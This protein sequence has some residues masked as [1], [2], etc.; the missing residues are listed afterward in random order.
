MTEK[1]NTRLETLAE[2]D[3]VRMHMPGHKGR[4]SFPN[5]YQIDFTEITGSDDLHHPEEILKALQNRAAALYNTGAAVILPGSTTAGIIGAMLAF[6]RPGDF[7]LI[8][9]NAHRS[10]Y[11]A[12]AFGRLTPVFFSPECL[13]TQHTVRALLNEHPEASG[14]LIVSPDYFGRVANLP[15]IAS[16]AHSRGLRLITDAAHG[17][18]LHFCSYDPALMQRAGTESDAL[19]QSTHKTLGAFTQTALLHTLNEEDAGAIARMLALFESSSP[20]YLLMAGL[21]KALDQAE[22]SAALV[23]KRIADRHAACMAAQ[24]STDPIQLIRLSEPYDTSKWLYRTPQGCGF[25]TEKLLEA[26]GIYCELAFP[27]GVL[28]MTGIGTTESDIDALE[29][30]IKTCCHSF[31]GLSCSTGPLFCQER[32]DMNPALPMSDAV[33]QTGETTPLSSAAGQICLDFII[34]YPPGTPIV[35]PGTRLT[36]TQ[37]D[38]IHDMINEGCSVTG[39]IE[40][41]GTLTLRVLSETPDSLCE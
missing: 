40:K 21:E 27:D 23:F 17:S 5:P 26:Q 18:H 1:L 22:K 30:A 14:L 10:A 41:N 36:Q 35:I 16:E 19:I 25:Q 39:P 9:D 38:R 28:C 12:L 24:H 4:G 6:F 20:S 32:E 15:M 7:V 34:P 3:R 13:K 8:P 37:T 33:F 29:S 31:A 11:T 2:K